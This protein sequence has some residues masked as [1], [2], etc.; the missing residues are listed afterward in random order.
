MLNDFLYIRLE[1]ARYYTFRKSLSV[2]EEQQRE[3]VRLLRDSL[4][5]SLHTY[6]FCLFESGIPLRDAPNTFNSDCT[7][8]LI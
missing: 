7:L 8:R 5:T 3:L 1:M 6:Y 2:L 4:R